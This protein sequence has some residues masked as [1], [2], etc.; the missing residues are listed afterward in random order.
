VL[1]RL[2]GLETE[3]VLRFR[4]A[5]RVSNRHLYQRLL[6]GL[7][8][9]LPLAP[10]L[11][12]PDCWFLA[13]GGGLRFER[14]PFYA[15]LP[16]S[17]FVE[18]ATPECRGP[19]ELLRYQRA[20]DVLLSRYAAST[21]G[22]DGDVTLLKAGHDADGH[23]FGGHENYEATVADGPGLWVWRVPL[24]PVLFVLVLVISLG[25]AAALLLAPLIAAPVAILGRLLRRDSGRIYSAVV[26]RLVSPSRTPG[27]LIGSMFLSLM[28]FRRVRRRLL[29]FLVS[30]VILT[31]PR[32]VRPDGRFVL[33]ARAGAVH[34]TCGVTA[35]AWRSVFYFCHYIKS[36]ANPVEGVA[37]LFRRRQRLQITVGDSNMAQHAEFLK[38]GTTLLVLDVIEAGGLDDAPRLVR[39][40]RALRAFSDD[41][42]LKATARLTDGRRVRALDI[43]RFYLDAC[44]DYV[45][46]NSAGD[47]RAAHV[48]RLWKDTLDALERDPS[49]LVGRLDW[50][51][52]QYLLDA[53][54]S[55]AS[56]DERRKL[57][58]RYHELSPE[59]YY[60]QLEAAGV[61]PVV[62]EPEEIVTAMDLPPEGTP[63]AARG[64]L[65]R[66]VAGSGGSVRAGWGSAVVT[67]ALGTRVVR[68]DGR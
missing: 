27:Q 12:G 33:S 50:V 64:Q 29:P 37:P 18:G 25:D 9:R 24:V 13:N 41:P 35:A 34:S 19:G 3:Y 53:A 8:R 1:D 28:A 58:L 30:R 16:E 2:A 65:I 26:A 51:T 5:R 48:L 49:V 31:G 55:E 14:L 22:A 46:R 52:K 39:P 57:D 20:Q 66:R 61:A 54:G 67:D 47:A 63:A 15:P 4:G 40:L 44:R 36:I 43:Q 56:V 62:V 17:G 11:A 10:A 32:A 23:H 60:L 38:V 6:A 45:D 68:L 59:G 42:D 21:G 7:R